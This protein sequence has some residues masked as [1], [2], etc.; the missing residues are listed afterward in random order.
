MLAGAMLAVPHGPAAAARTTSP[1]RFSVRNLTDQPLITTQVRVATDKAGNQ[2]QGWS[3]TFGDEFPYPGQTIQPGQIIYFQLA[4]NYNGPAGQVT[5]SSTTIDYTIGAGGPAVHVS[6]YQ[7]GKGWPSHETSFGCISDDAAWTC[8]HDA[9]GADVTG[10]TKQTKVVTDKQQQLE[11]V[12]KLCQLGNPNVSCTFDPKPTLTT[13][14]MPYVTV[15]DVQYNYTEENSKHTWAQEW[16]NGTTMEVGGSYSPVDIEVQDVIK[17]EVKVTFDH[18]WGTSNSSEIENFVYVPPDYSGWIEAE[19]PAWQLTGNLHI[20]LG[21]ETWTLPEVT[22]T[23][24][25]P[26]T[27]TCPGQVDG[28][29]AGFCWT[30][31][32]QKKPIDL[33]K[34]PPP[35]TPPTS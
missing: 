24:P 1:D 15:G 23:T 4:V 29:K 27:G 22:F 3:H 26:P 6:A 7:N 19:I 34:N 5:P 30:P 12:N 32:T 16:D 25:A 8:S 17:V 10:A 13:T 20:V 2:D 31:R 33:S 28:S 9:H 18:E 21:N 11:L 35:P 14:M